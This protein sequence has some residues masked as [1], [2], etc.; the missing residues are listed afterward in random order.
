MIVWGVTLRAASVFSLTWSLHEGLVQSE[1]DERL[2]QFPQKVLQET[3]QHVDVINLIE[4]ERSFPLDES[5]SELLHQ[6]LPSR[7]SVQSSLQTAA[8]HEPQWTSNS[9]K[10]WGRAHLLQPPPLYL[11]HTL[12]DQLRHSG[13]DRWG[14]TLQWVL[15]RKRSAVKRRHCDLL[16]LWTGCSSN[17]WVFF[18]LLHFI[19]QS[20][21]NVS[22]RSESIT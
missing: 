3:T 2:L 14:K 18:L 10:D 21:Y 15:K 19:S 1:G 16:C 22:Y 13:M 5:V 4:H 11:S 6:T 17:H 9:R 8:H 7:N 12:H 20:I